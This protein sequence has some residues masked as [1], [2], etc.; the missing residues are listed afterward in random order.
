LSSN[1]NEC[2]PLNAELLRC[3]GE[4]DQLA[5]ELRDAQSLA[6]R[7]DAAARAARKAGECRLTLS[8]PSW[9]RLELSA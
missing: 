8:D 5:G 1:V 9:N 7:A 3:G 6:A 4:R 2:K